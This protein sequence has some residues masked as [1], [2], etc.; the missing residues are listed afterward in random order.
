M[1]EMSVDGKVH[2]S[3]PSY[4]A[5]GAH[6]PTYLVC[7]LQSRVRQFKGKPCKAV[8][9][10]YWSIYS[11]AGQMPD[12]TTVASGYVY[13]L[14]VGLCDVLTCPGKTMAHYHRAN[15]VNK[16]LQPEDFL[17]REWLAFSRYLNP[18]KHVWE[19]LGRRDAVHQ[20]PPICEPELWRSMLAEMSKLPLRLA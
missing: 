17:H 16:C 10:T 12:S 7:N 9:E 20:P 14:R 8:F 18:I 19:I 3:P 4:A 2:R 11:P 15:T 13:I 1:K 5:D 6:Y